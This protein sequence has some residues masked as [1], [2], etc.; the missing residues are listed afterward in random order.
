MAD[1]IQRWAQ[2]HY[3]QMERHPEGA[4]V[5]AAD[6]AAHEAAAVA[7]AIDAEFEPRAA[8]EQRNYRA[9]YAEGQ[10]DER[11]RSNARADEWYAKGR[12]HSIEVIRADLR[13]ELLLTPRIAAVIDAA[14]QEPTCP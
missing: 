14:P 3:A 7:A 5:L 9:G 8:A 1:P 11:A 13:R 6:A 12:Q 4:F 2:P 10:R